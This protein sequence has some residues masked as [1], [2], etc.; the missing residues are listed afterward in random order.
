M[1]ETFDYVFRPFTEKDLKLMAKWLAEPHVA[2]WWGVDINEELE[3]I[4]EHIGSIS[5]EPLIIEMSGKPIGYLQT[6]DPHLEDDHPYQDQPLGTLGID[7]TIGAPEL[8]H[9]GHGSRILAQFAEMLF[10]EGAPRVIIDPDPANAA[11]IRAYQKAG[12][13]AF[14]TR[15]SEY[16]PTLM[17]ARDNPGMDD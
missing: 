14:D 7:L 4:R 9:K 10:E 13:A 1:A 12:F 8:I 17:M 15:D 11:A 5:V 16:G 6:Y 3:A 2:K